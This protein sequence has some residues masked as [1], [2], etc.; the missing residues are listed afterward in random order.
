MRDYG[1]LA[2]SFDFA[3]DPE[4]YSP[5]PAAKRDERRIAFYARAA[6]DR[7][8]VDLGL[9]ALELL[10]ARVG[11]LQVDLFGNPKRFR[12]QRFPCTDR[13]VLTPVQLAELYRRATLGMVF[14][15]TNHSL[16]P[17]EMM[18]CGLPVV[19]LDSEN[20]TSV[21]PRDVFTPVPPTPHAVAGA[22]ERMLADEPRR[23]RQVSMALEHVRGLSWEKSAR[24]VERALLDALEPAASL[25]SGL[26]QR[27]H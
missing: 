10:A 13:G 24:Q 19:D 14:S 16:I 4:I 18:A 11:E 22:L 12:P 20:V 17:L 7:R 5:G 25:S 2:Y 27:E 1:A 15:T 6:T 23:R 8:A 9:L 26:L 21:L 3:Y